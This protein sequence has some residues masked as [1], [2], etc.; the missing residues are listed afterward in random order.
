MQATMRGWP[1]ACRRVLEVL[2]AAAW[3]AG[4]SR[5]GAA[6]YVYTN[7][8]EWAAVV[9]GRQI[10]ATTAAGVGM[11]E[12]VPAPTA[13]NI[14]VGS[15]LTFLAATT[16]L[17]R[18][19]RVATLEPGA[20]FTFNDNEIGPS[21]P[22]G[23][24]YENALSIGDIDN[25]EDDDCEIVILGGPPLRALAFELGDNEPGLNDP[26]LT[27]YGTSGQVLGGPFPLPAVSGGYAFLG[28]VSDEPIG[29][30]VV[31]GD[32]T[33][34]QGNNDDMAIRHF[35]FADPKAPADMPEI[36][37]AGT[38]A[39]DQVALRWSSASNHVYFVERSA[40]PTTGYSC[41]ASNLPTEPPANA[42]TG[43]VGGA[44]AYFRVR[45]RR[46]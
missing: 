7:E 29:R 22:P 46:N 4:G 27:V 2:A 37:V 18:S 44:A 20:T 3:A 42:Y 31:D 5:A 26:G 13:N 15:N 6:V 34:P 10:L 14:D 11:A 43:S 17:S 41:I 25:Y 45:A 21:S 33:V 40:A 28:V 35:Q 36:Q 8:T 32:N 24:G 38:A 19:F 9:T 39:A 12:E 30:A 23:A 16:G 1:A